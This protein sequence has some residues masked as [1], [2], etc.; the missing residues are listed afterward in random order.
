MGRAQGVARA[1]KFV[2]SHQRQL[3]ESG[4]NG[5][6]VFLTQALVDL[7]RYSGFAWSNKYF[8]NCTSRV[9]AGPRTVPRSLPST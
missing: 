8:S 2:P 4:H 3:T 5:M 7:E 9:A 6:P 1:E